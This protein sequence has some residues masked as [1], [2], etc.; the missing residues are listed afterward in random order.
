MGIVDEMTQ[1]GAASAQNL[2]D[3]IAAVEG[4]GRELN[5]VTS[6]TDDR[7]RML[8]QRS[9]ER[10]AAGEPPRRLEG[11]PFAIKDV[12]DVAGF[13]TTMGSRVSAGPEPRATAPVVHLLE[14]GG[15]VPVAKTN[16]QEYSYGIL[17]DESAFGRVVNPVDSALCTGGSSS[18]SAALVAFGVVPLAVGTDTAGSVRVPAACQGVIGFKPTFGAISTEGVF[19]LSPSFDTVGLFAREIPLIAAA[20]GAI[21]SGDESDGG[22]VNDAAADAVA[23]DEAASRR[24][25]TVDTGLLDSAGTFADD[26]RDWARRKLTE[27]RQSRTEISTTSAISG[28][29]VKVIDEGLAIYDI[30]RRYE[31]FVLHERYL[32]E[33]GESYQPGV[34]A[35]ILSGQ[36]ITEAE[37][38]AQVAALEE[39]RASAVS[40]FDEVDFIVTPAIEGDV[41]RWDEID[42]GSAAKF[43]RYSLP[44]N[45]LGWP[46]VTLPVRREPGVGR[47]PVSVQIVGPPHWDR[48]LLEFAAGLCGSQ[49]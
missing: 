13:P 24:T 5:A 34:W 31:A 43:M 27:S 32:D 47:P 41:I 40:F 23:V 33:Q 4:I 38:R 15:A 42:D 49:L 7:A 17:G 29:L 14:R 37:Y 45:V 35:K 39:F 30:V 22:A 6:V 16:C 1:R 46:A 25:I 26:S 36:S 20:F 19:P 18:G 48:E 44:F 2:D 21:T 28:D 12:I 3:T 8:T 10:T 9:A 11:V